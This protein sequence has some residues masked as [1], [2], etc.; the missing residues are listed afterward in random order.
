MEFTGLPPFIKRGRF[1][2]D[3]VIGGNMV[4]FEGDNF[5]EGVV[6]RVHRLVRECEDEVYVNVLKVTFASEVVGF[7]G[8]QQRYGFCLTVLVF[9]L[10]SLADQNS[11]DSH[12]CLAL[13]EVFR[14]QRYRDCILR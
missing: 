1:L 14:C 7:R 3:E 11:A 4:R 8:I 12:R 2:H 6:P 5:V 10:A 13:R 9:H